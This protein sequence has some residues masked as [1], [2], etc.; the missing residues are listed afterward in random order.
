MVWRIVYYAT[1][2]TPPRSI[3]HLF[4]SW[5]SNQSSKV[6]NLIWV[7]V[8]VFCWAIWRCRNDIIFH[9]IKVNSILQIIFG[10]TYWLRFW[11]QLQRSEQAK[12]TIS[13]I[14]RNLETTALEMKKEDGNISI[15]CFS[16]PYVSE[17]L[18]CS[19]TFVLNSKCNIRLC[20]HSCIEAGYS[21]HYQKKE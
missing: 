16:F 6:R 15:V 21:I 20:M 19:L 5:L 13:L 12:D 9:K 18:A 11:A 10:G 7:G 2:L 4:G 17:T 3:R 8:A 1:G 14:S